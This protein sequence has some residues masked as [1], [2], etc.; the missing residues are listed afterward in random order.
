MPQFPYLSNGDKDDSTGQCLRRQLADKTEAA[1]RASGPVSGAEAPRSP[2]RGQPPGAEPS[3]LWAR[4]R[5]A[6]W[7]RGVGRAGRRGPQRMAVS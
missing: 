3:P 2:G 6:A 5:N 4:G 7:E 1:F